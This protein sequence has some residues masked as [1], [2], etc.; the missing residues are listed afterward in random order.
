MNMTMSAN[1]KKQ[2]TAGLKKKYNQVAITPSGHFLYPTGK[3]GLEGLGYADHLIAGLPDAVTDSF[4]GVGNPFSLGTIP[5]GSKI[6]DIGCG[7]GIDSLL[8]AEL[9]G[10]SGEVLGID[11]NQKMVE[12]ANANKEKMNAANVRFQITTVDALTAMD[13][14]FDL[15]L[16]NGVFNLIPDKQY[17]LTAAARLLKPGGKIY[18]ADQFLSGSPNKDVDQRVATWFQ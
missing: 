4:C 10:P 18:L 9:V 3:E 2:I 5:R 12:K 8:A 6:L 14:F 1:H 17:A 13:R 16:S 7:A 11:L 15:V